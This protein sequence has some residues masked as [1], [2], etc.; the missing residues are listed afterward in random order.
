MGCSQ[1]DSSR[2]FNDT[3]KRLTGRLGI[4]GYGKLKTCRIDG[5]LRFFA[6]INAEISPV[7]NN[8]FSGFFQHPYI[9]VLRGG[10]VHGEGLFFSIGGGAIRRRAEMGDTPPAPP[11]VPYNFNSC[12]QLLAICREEEKSIA[13]IVMANESARKIFGNQLC[14]PS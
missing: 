8:A 5:T 6:V 2:K 12:N 11:T 1:K 9:A 10:A 3:G 14:A 7:E 4:G 13:Q